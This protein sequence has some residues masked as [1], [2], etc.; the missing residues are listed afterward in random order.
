MVFSMATKTICFIA[1]LLLFIATINFSL[2]TNSTYNEIIKQSSK[3]VIHEPIIISSE[4]DFSKY[5][6]ISGSGTK[7]D[8]YLIENLVINIVYGDTSYY[9]GIEIKDTRSYIVIRNCEFN[10]RNTTNIKK[11]D[12]YDYL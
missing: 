2:K 3:R 12:I 5:D 9:V 8:P 4:K 11:N 6:F 7:R 1:M 10:W